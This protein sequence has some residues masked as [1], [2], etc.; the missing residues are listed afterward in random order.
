MQEAGMAKT[1]V[2][3]WASPVVFV[4]IKNYSL[5]FCVDY[6]RLDAVTVR[7]SYPIPV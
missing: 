2:S 5:R 6:N 4:P 1:A 7:D 3:E